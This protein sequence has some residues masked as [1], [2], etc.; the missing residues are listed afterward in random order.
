MKD[1][2]SKFITGTHGSLSVVTVNAS[3]IERK[4]RAKQTMWIPEE[5]AE[6]MVRSPVQEI[7]VPGIKKNEDCAGNLA[8]REIYMEGGWPHGGW[9]TC[10]SKKK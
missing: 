10:L 3:V 2:S 7:P 9:V 6:E 8:V 5:V 1:K 4:K